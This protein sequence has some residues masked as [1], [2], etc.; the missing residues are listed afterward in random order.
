M[1]ATASPLRAFTTILAAL[2]LC[3]SGSALDPASAVAVAGVSGTVT[4]A[5]SHA[6]LSGAR[7]SLFAWT[8]RGDGVASFD[9]LGTKLTGTDGS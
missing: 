3:L 5:A 8:D 4:D 7:V 2:C 6:G 1:S 9:Y